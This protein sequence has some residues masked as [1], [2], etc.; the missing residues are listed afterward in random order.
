[1]C[2]AAGSG[3]TPMISIMKSVLDNEP[4][5]TVTLIYGNRRSN[6][7]MFKDELNFVKNRYMNRFQWINIMNYDWSLGGDR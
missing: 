1:M 2:I 4:G 6:S 7:V 5:S 3:I